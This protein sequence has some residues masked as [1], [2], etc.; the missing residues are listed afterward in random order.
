MRMVKPRH[1]VWSTLHICSRCTAATV[2]F[3]QACMM[4]S[5]NADDRGRTRGEAEVLGRRFPVEGWL[6]LKETL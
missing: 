2:Y 3:G 5:K 1:G 4:Q 6:R